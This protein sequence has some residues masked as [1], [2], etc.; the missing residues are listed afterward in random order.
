M[1]GLRSLVHRGPGTLLLLVFGLALAGAGLA[2]SAGFSGAIAA[3]LVGLLFTGE[4]AESMRNRFAPLRNIF[5]IVLPLFRTQYF[6]LRCIEISTG[7]PFIRCS[8]YR[9][10]IL[11]RLVDCQRHD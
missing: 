5:F 2:S 7:C 6:L 4:V 9:R 10:K 11:R 1:P 3:F 8:R